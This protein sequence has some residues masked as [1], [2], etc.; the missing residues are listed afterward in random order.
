MQGVWATV[1]LGGAA[2]AAQAYEAI[3][4]FFAFTSS[5]FNISTFIAVWLLR[6]KYPDAARP[7]RAR[8]Y[9]VTLIIVLIIQ[10]WFCITTL[11]TAFVPSVLGALLTSS[12]LLFYYRHRLRSFLQGLRV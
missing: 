8:G 7:Y 2:F 12:G 11:I 4:D 5:V 3:I 6:R 10:I 9:P 1:L